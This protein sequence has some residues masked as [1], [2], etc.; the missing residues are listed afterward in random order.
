MLTRLVSLAS[1]RKA[2]AVICC[3]DLITTISFC[4]SGVRKPAA[5]KAAQPIAFAF[6]GGPDTLG[7]SFAKK[8]AAGGSSP[9]RLRLDKEGSTSRGCMSLTSE[10]DDCGQ[11]S[12]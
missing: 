8:F 4:V 12:L 5:L 11:S 10:I 6:P 2:K 9:N 7:E 3:F 1:Q